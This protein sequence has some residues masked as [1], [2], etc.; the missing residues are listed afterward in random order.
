MDADFK[1]KS[2]NKKLKVIKRFLSL[3]PHTKKE[4]KAHKQWCKKNKAE[5]SRLWS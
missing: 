2:K 5:L 3:V 1:S 4:R